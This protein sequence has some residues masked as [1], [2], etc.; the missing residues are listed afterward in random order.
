[1]YKW[2]GLLL[3]KFFFFGIEIRTEIW[4]FS[5][6]YLEKKIDEERENKVWKIALVTSLKYMLNNRQ[7]SH[8][9]LIVA[10]FYW[11]QSSEFHQ[12]AI[13]CGD[14]G[15]RLSKFAKVDQQSKCY[16]LCKLFT[17]F[18][19]FLY[20]LFFFLIIKNVFKVIVED[21]V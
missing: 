13:S 9:L 8:F 18:V 16:Q 4:S 15:F 3:K 21:F 12:M 20:L 10:N 7:R 2:R 17:F 6:F 5:L 19:D 14:L 1:M 11:Y